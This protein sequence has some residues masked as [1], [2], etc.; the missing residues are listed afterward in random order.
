MPPL[1]S[2]GQPGKATLTHE[3]LKQAAGGTH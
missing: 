2:P 1:G 3:D